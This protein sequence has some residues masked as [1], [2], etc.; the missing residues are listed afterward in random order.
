MN[1]LIRPLAYDLNPALAK[2]YALLD[3]HYHSVM[4]LL[5]TPRKAGRELSQRDQL[6]FEEKVIG[7]LARKLIEFEAFA[8]SLGPHILALDYTQELIERVGFKVRSHPRH[9][10]LEE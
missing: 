5:T 6:A 9:H 3:N 4:D 7:K 10:N 8:K 1:P 2:K